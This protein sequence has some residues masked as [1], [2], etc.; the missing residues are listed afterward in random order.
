MSPWGIE[1][2]RYVLGEG[3]VAAVGRAGFLPRH[4]VGVNET[5]E[6]LDREGQRGRVGSGVSAGRSFQ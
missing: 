4:G 3:M 6:R 1:G 5:G 2:E